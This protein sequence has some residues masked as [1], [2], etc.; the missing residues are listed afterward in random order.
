MPI[1]NLDH[2]SYEADHTL[3]LD[4]VSLAIDK[5]ECVSLVGASGSGKSTLLKLCADLITPTSGEIAYE[6]KPYTTY[7]PLSLRKKISYC[8]QLPYLFG[9]TVYDN[10]AFPFEIRKERPDKSRMCELLQAFNLD[11]RFLHKGI[12]GLSGGEKQ[13]IALCRNLMYIPEILLLDEATSALDPDSARVVEDS[14]YNL[15]KQGVTILWITHNRDQSEGI[16]KRRLT[17]ANGKLVEEEV[18]GQ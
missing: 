8:V 11:E 10:L 1:I 7:N 14:I 12:E 4:N 6:S 17:M 9:E 3:I 18:F 2:I 13:R 16:F 5:G 15:N